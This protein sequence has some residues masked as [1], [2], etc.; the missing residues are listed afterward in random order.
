M[1]N[2]RVQA[3]DIPTLE[4][5]LEM[6]AYWQAVR[7][8][9]DHQRDYSRHF[10]RVLAERYPYKVVVTKLARLSKQGLVECGSPPGYWLTEAGERE[11]ERLRERGEKLM[12][13]PEQLF[14]NALL[15]EFIAAVVADPDWRIDRNE[16]DSTVYEIRQHGKH[17]C[18]VAIHE[19]PA[20]G[21][22]EGEDE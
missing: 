2:R 15:A 18:F 1:S 7:P 22:P 11:L 10:T 5:L 17:F 16:S 13:D 12:V 14:E 6:E 8:Q 3:K 20:L 9:P 4:V 21:H 19:I